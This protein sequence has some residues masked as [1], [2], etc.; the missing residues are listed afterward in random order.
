MAHSLTV[1][2]ANRIVAP[3]GAGPRLQRSDL[4][5]RIEGADEPLL[6]L[7]APSGFGKTQVLAEWAE[8]SH[9]PVAWYSCGLADGDPHTF[10]ER[11]VAGLAA[12]WATLGSDTKLLLD[13]PTW[14][15][16]DVTTAL[17]HDLEDV[18]ADAAIVIDDAHL[19]S[20]SHRMLTELAVR[21]TGCQ[22]LL[23]ASQHNLVMSTARLRVSGVLAEVRAADLEFSNREVGEL[24]ALTASS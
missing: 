10:W 24:C 21:L 13:R 5:S 8:S 20:S 22:R 2:E 7:L 12:R 1:P 4:V 19:A 17:V 9:R 18:P 16:A 3:R 14:E 6:L 15:D 23:L 11:L